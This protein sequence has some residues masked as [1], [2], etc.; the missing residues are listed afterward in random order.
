MVWTDPFPWLSLGDSNSVSVG[1]AVVGRL[2]YYVEFF[3][4]VSTEHGA[5]WL[6][7]VDTWLTYRVSANVR[8]DGGAYIGAT[9]AADNWHPW[10]GVTLRY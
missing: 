1:H 10:M 5:D 8:L 4:N 2:S 3:S 9:A 7:T 6:G